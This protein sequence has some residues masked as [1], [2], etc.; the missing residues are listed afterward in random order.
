MEAGSISSSIGA[1]AATA[2]AAAAAPIRNPYTCRPVSTYSFSTSASAS[3]LSTTEPSPAGQNTGRRRT[4]QDVNQQYQL[5]FRPESSSSS[6]FSSSTAWAAPSTKKGSTTRISPS[7]ALQLYRSLPHLQQQHQQQQQQHWN[8][9]GSSSTLRQQQGGGGEVLVLHL[10][11]D[12]C[13]W[14]RLDNGRIHELAGAA[15]TAKTQLALQ[16]CVDCAVQGY[17]CSYV[18]LKGGNSGMA[19]TRL[20]HRLNQMILMATAPTVSA[21]G[22]SSSSSAAA[23]TAAATLRHDILSRIHLRGIRNADELVNDLHTGSLTSSSSSS[24]SNNRRT[25]TTAD[26]IRLLVIDSVADVF[27][28]D[29]TTD[30][31]QRALRF[32]QWVLALRRDHA[33]CPILM[34]NQVTLNDTMPALGL[35]WAHCVN[36]SFLVQKHDSSS[37]LSSGTPPRR[38]LSLQRS[39]VHGPHSI[40]FAVETGGCRVVATEP[41]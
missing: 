30:Y 23:T 4:L 28:G 20:A 13:A 17:H 15:G 27:R 14:T 25:T 1:E 40:A 5:K 10:L 39:P 36:A 21:G 12:R 33:D 31:T 38:V 7:N 8:E 32:V 22:S 35:T 26:T 2:A 34:L 24:S 18:I 9:N 16:A 6:S 41:W 3:S 29:A 19:L 11:T 37:W